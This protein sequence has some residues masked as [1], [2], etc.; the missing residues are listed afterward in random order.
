MKKNLALLA[1]VA[2]LAFSACS[3][4]KKH[5]DHKG[6]LENNKEAMKKGFEAFETGN[7]DSLG[8]YIAEDAKDHSLP[9]EIKTTG[10]Q[11][12]KDIIAMHHTAFTNLKV[13]TLNITAEGDMVYAHYNMKGDN[14]GAWGAMPATNKS[15]DVNGV[16]VV[17]FENGKAVEHWGYFEE[18]KMF[19]QLGL[20]PEEGE[21]H[22]GE[23]K[24][25]LKEKMKEAK[26]EV[27]EEVREVKEKLKK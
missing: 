9:P 8:K 16:D 11:A 1:G 22:A 13:N 27:K 4:M 15:I 5:D 25:G 26:E 20:M 18:V 21:T 17:R 23:N 19:K 3:D 14:T 10:L 7:T 24:E 2:I 6:S 12:V